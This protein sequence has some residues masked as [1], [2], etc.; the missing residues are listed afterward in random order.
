MISDPGGLLA[1]AGSKYVKAPG[2]DS[3]GGLGWAVATVAETIN[4]SN[5]SAGLM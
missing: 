5:R 4:S 2:C 1:A 3:M